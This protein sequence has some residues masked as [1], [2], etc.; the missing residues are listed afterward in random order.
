MYV[1]MLH[2]C[3]SFITRLEAHKIQNI[4]E[5]LLGHRDLID[6]FEVKVTITFHEERNGFLRMQTIHKKREL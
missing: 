4:L 5:V 6:I 1:C 2:R 3:F